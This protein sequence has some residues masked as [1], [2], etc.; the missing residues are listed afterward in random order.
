MER[1]QGYSTRTDS[2][3]SSYT[4]TGLNRNAPSEP[5]SSHSVSFCATDDITD[6]KSLIDSVFSKQIGSLSKEQ[7]SMIA[8]Q[9]KKANSADEFLKLILGQDIITFEDMKNPMYGEIGRSINDDFRNCFKILIHAQRCLAEYVNRNPIHPHTVIDSDEILRNSLLIAT[10]YIQTG[11]N[12]E[13][14]RRI[15]QRTEAQ[16]RTFIINGK[17]NS[18]PNDPSI[19]MKSM[20]DTTNG[21]HNELQ[22]TTQGSRRDIE[23]ISSTIHSSPSRDFEEITTPHSTRLNSKSKVTSSSADQVEDDRMET[24]SSF[25]SRK[26]ESRKLPES[27]KWIKENESRVFDESAMDVMT[28]EL[29][30][31]FV[32]TKSSIATSLEGK[33]L[34]I[35]KPRTTIQRREQKELQK[36]RRDVKYKI[37]IQ[38]FQETVRLQ[39]E[40]MYHRKLYG[41][42][43]L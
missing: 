42:L 10:K 41:P 24:C 29:E 25:S 32:K 38:L 22:I 34:F 1:P 36:T 27:R 28:S 43:E 31:T 14:V 12:Y 9:F 35:L 2:S 33:E 16:C 20:K 18:R 15:Q 19:V 30:P 6:D 5:C 40:T 23:E 26:D 7:L 13:E 39:L 21:S 37:T 4:G 17:P 11:V 8:Q 3:S